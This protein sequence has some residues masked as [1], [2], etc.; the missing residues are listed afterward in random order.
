MAMVGERW[1]EGAESMCLEMPVEADK[2][3]E[4]KAGELEAKEELV[5]WVVV[6]DLTSPGPDQKPLI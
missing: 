3:G 5:T 4:E 2:T 6:A 1:G